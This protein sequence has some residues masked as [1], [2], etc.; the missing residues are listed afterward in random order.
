MKR[1]W[2]RPLARELIIVLVVKLA[3]IIS[4]KIMFYASWAYRMM[5]GKVT[6]QFIE[7]HD[8]AAY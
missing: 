1:L 4:I 3:L 7:T 6:A 2:Q 8:K 5:A